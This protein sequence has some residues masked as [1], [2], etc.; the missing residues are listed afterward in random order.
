ML[1]PYRNKIHVSAMISENLAAITNI[2]NE[3]N[4]VAFVSV[5][6]H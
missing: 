6:S 3:Y 1:R 4:R 2:L 5:I